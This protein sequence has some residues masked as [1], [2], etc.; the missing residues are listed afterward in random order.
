MSN[1]ALDIPFDEPDGSTIAYDF[2]PGHHHAAIEAGRF[3]P[4]RFG[5]CAYFPNE[6]KAEII[7]QVVDFGQDF[8][9]MIWVMAAPV[10]SFPTQ[11]YVLF[12]FPGENNFRRIMVNNR[13]QNWTHF[14]V[15]QGGNVLTVYINGS[16]V[17]TISHP[18]GVRPTGFAL[19]NNSPHSTG[20]FCYLDD[21]KVVAG[22]AIPP[23]K[24]EEDINNTLQPVNFSVNNINFKDY[25][26]WV[27]RMEG[28]FDL[29]DRKDPLTVEWADY[30]GEVVDLLK[31]VWDVREIELRCWIKGNGLDNMTSKWME[32]KDHFMQ[33]GTVRFAIE[34]GTKP[35]AFE[36]YQKENLKFEKDKWYE[37]D[38][39][40]RFTL[41][42]REP[43]PIKK[44]LKVSG[45]NSAS[46]TLTSEKL[47]SIYWGDGSRTE[48]VKGTNVT[49]THNYAGSGDYFIIV[50]GVIEDISN[51]S[52]S[53]P[54]VWNKY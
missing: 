38:D 4:G 29:P 5:N 6:G 36:V 20:G 12:K 41:N 32:F 25:G 27:E 53:A 17:G 9:F 37:G 26:V 54:I 40:G 11:S 7:E 2:S 18:S 50:A 1:I 10:N 13:L 21:G 39:F 31:P 14:A 48:N 52:S 43:Q 34:A 30:H 49:R 19:L 24:I 15:T 51:F 35:L 45:Q 42:L 23:E 16:N 44:L 8:T 46:V 3:I 33:G 28:V 22:E 47:V